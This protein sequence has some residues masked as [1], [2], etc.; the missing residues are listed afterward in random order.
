MVETDLT[1]H[2]YDRFSI[3]CRLRQAA[4]MK[5][6]PENSPPSLMWAIETTTRRALKPQGSIFQARIPTL[7]ITNIAGRLF[8]GSAVSLF[9][10]QFGKAWRGF[11]TANVIC[12]L[13]TNGILLT[14]TKTPRG[15][16]KGSLETCLKLVEPKRQDL[17]PI[18]PNLQAEMYTQESPALRQTED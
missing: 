2:Y 17:A 12:V 1:H 11:N 5:E 18:F 8:P 16:N 3:T 4:L 9:L 10:N 6:M 14:L 13:I 7:W 15:A